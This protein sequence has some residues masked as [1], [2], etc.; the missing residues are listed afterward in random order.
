MAMFSYLLSSLCAFVF[1][2][3]KACGDYFVFDVM[4]RECEGLERM[5]MGRLHLSTFFFSLFQLINQINLA[6]RFRTAGNQ[7]FYVP[8]DYYASHE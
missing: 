1:S 7:S 6:V 2:T 5:R 3:K 4:E 8:I